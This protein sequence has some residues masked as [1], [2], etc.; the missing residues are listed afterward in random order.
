[1]DNIL[2][3][4]IKISSALITPTLAIVGAFILVN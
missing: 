3:T 4:I 1:M 2:D